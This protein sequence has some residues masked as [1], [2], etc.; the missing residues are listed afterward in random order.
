MDLRALRITFQLI[1]VSCFITHDI[2]RGQCSGRRIGKLFSG[3]QKERGKV[4]EKQKSC[5]G[6]QGKD[7]VYIRSQYRLQKIKERIQNALGIEDDPPPSSN[8][9]TK[10][11][12]PAPI[13]DKDESILG[14]DENSEL[15]KERQILLAEP[16]ESFLKILFHGCAFYF[17]KLSLLIR[18]LLKALGVVLYVN[19]VS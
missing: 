15:K 19:R 6:C 18:Q 5:F 1:F 7:S 8:D 2:L 17:S 12:L 3:V 9:T 10:N 4:S 11:L 13:Q 14:E 16:S